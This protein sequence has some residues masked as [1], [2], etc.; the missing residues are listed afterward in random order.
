MAAWWTTASF[1]LSSVCSGVRT[2]RIESP[3]DQG[4]THTDTSEP[5]GVQ[6]CASSS[7]VLKPILAQNW[8][9]FR[10][11]VG[12]YSTS[13]SPRRS[14]GIVRSDPGLKW[15]G[16]SCDTQMWVIASSTSGPSCVGECRAQPSSKAV[17]TSQGSV[18]RPTS[19]R[20]TTKEAWFTQSIVGAADIGRFPLGSGA[21]RR[22]ERRTYHRAPGLRPSPRTRP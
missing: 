13:M 9:T 1:T 17:P 14:S 12:W 6:R 5:M 7:R 10:S 11:L 8:R 15:S 2:A 21:P 3:L 16:C 22:T 4:A 18:S 19:P 20:R